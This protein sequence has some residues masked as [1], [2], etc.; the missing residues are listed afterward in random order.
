MPLLVFVYQQ[1]TPG[2]ARSP[3]IKYLGFVQQVCLQAKGI[4]CHWTNGIKP[5]KTKSKELK[6]NSHKKFSDGLTIYKYSQMKS[7]Y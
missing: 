5:L 2:S 1:V 7:Q 4:A 3:N 6:S